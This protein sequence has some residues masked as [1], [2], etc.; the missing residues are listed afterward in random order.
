MANVSGWI[1]SLPSLEDIKLGRFI[2]NIERPQEGYH[3][4]SMPNDPD[5]TVKEFSISEQ[6]QSEGKAS[7][8][9]YITR[10]ISIKYSGF[11]NLKIQIDEAN[12]N[13][14]SLD[15]ST[16][17][18]DKAIGLLETKS[19]IERAALRREKMYMVVGLRTLTNPRITI[20]STQEQKVMSGLKIAE[21]FSFIVSGVATPANTSAPNTAHGRNQT[22]SSAQMCFQA[23]GERVC[24][25]FYRKIKYGWLS[26]R[27]IDDLK[28][29][30]TRVWSCIEGD[31]RDAY[32]TDDEDEE[33]EDMMYVDFDDCDEI[34]MEEQQ[35]AIKQ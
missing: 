25:L 29:S 4:P 28:L 3:E 20:T 21:I 1:P 10:L 35:F 23:P 19:W 9:A 27:K 24:S 30:K 11:T 2:T 32:E 7:P 17:W 26:S 8:G 18:F 15:N 16:A 31:R 14:Y 34:E 12:G 22:S 33:E 6:N 13:E 5:S